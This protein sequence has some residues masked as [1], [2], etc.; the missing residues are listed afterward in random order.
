MVCPEGNVAAL[1]AEGR[2]ARCSEAVSGGGAA[3]IG[4]GR[5]GAALAGVRRRVRSQNGCNAK[6]INQACV[7]I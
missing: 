3:P 7:K 5:G 4:G 6:T 1:L 2:A